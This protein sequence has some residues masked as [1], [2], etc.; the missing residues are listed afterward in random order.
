MKI[1]MKVFYKQ[2]VSFLLVIVRYAQSTQNSK[3]VISLLYLKTE[4][5]DKVYFFACRQTLMGMAWLA[6]ITQ[7][8]KLIKSF[9][10][11]G[12]SEGQSWIF[13]QMSIILFFKLILWF[14][15][16]VAR[17]AWSSQNNKY[18]LSLQ[19]LNNEL[20]YKVDFCMLI[21]MK[22]FYKLMLFLMGFSR[23]TQC[24]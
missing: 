11:Q 13:V 20:N 16:V 10:S 19:Y 9:V 7:Y 22:V 6:Q 24:T 23:H 18:T 17:H 15:M 21:N 4:G 5:R 12:R 2:V 14:L 3:F 1:N 8:N